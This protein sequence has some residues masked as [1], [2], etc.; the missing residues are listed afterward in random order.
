NF[1]RTAACG[2]GIPPGGHCIISVRFHPTGSGLRAGSLT[3]ND[4][5]PDSPQTVPLSGTGTVVKL[6][7]QSATFPVQVIGTPSATRSIT[8]S[9]TGTA[10]LNV[11][12]ITLTGSNP[13]DFL[14]TN[15]CIPTLPAG[16]ACKIRVTF[17]PTDKDTRTA[18][19]SI[20]DDG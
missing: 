7:P 11:S 15:N 4:N 17:T 13:G 10:P 19:L 20:S 5:A 9:N 16:A 3:I 2:S 18:T 12:N 8:L 14:Q 1:T 6:N